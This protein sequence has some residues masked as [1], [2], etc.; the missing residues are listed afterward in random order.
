MVR[1]SAW[2]AVDQGFKPGWVKLKILEL[3]FAKHAVLRSKSKVFM[4]I[5]SFSVFPYKLGSPYLSRTLMMVESC[6]PNMSPLHTL[7]VYSA[8]FIKC[9]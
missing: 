3:L 7:F 8:D 2:S 9:N 6:Q 5:R 1:V 4:V